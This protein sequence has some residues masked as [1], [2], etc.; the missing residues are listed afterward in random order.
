MKLNSLK[1]VKEG[2]TQVIKFVWTLDSGEVLET[3]A[4]IK[5]RSAE[6]FVSCQI[7]CG[8]G[9]K[10]CEC[11]REWLVR[12]LE[13][14]EILDQVQSMM[15]QIQKSKFEIR[16]LVVSFSGTGEYTENDANVIK[17]MRMLISKYPRVFFVVTSNGSNYRAF[18]SLKKLPVLLAIS[19]HAPSD[20][21]RGKIIQ[22]NTPIKN[23]ILG[24]KDFFNSTGRKVV[25][26][27]IPISKIN[28]RM[29][30]IRKFCKI[31]DPKI[32]TIEL[33]VL[34]KVDGINDSFV[35]SPKITEIASYIRKKGFELSMREATGE[36]IK[37]ECGQLASYVDSQKQ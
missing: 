17:A 18:D 23:I 10:F 28:D 29:W 6:F 25:A 37:A 32:F 16:D 36:Q 13:A 9:C 8:G 11:S 2:P 15:T 31:L 19:L 14:S 26:R 27:Y 20:R 5:S 4:R 21:I 7:G 12:N 33:S 30:H 24:A 22:N 35:V 34:H 1:S 3:V